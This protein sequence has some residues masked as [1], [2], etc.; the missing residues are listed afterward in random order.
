MTVLILHGYTFAILELYESISGKTVHLS[1][2]LSSMEKNNKCNDTKF[3]KIIYTVRITA[4][5]VT[6][7]LK[8]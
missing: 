1:T 6:R 2:G 3:N 7:N 8:I 5:G 4:S